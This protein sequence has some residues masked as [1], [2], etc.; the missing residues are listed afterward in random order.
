MRRHF[1]LQREGLEPSQA[2]NRKVDAVRM[3]SGAALRRRGV[4]PDLGKDLA[5]A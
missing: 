3:I 5:D 1:Q 2:S 4:A